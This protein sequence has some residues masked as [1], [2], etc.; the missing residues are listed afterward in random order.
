MVF[1]WIPEF[2]PRW[3]DHLNVT[4]VFDWNGRYTDFCQLFNIECR[5]KPSIGYYNYRMFRLSPYNMEFNF[6]HNCCAFWV[7]RITLRISGCILLAIRCIPSRMGLI[8]RTPAA[9]PFQ[10]PDY[11]LRNGKQTIDKFNVGGHTVY[12]DVTRPVLDPDVS[13]LR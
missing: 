7:I 4:F 11:S 10:S 5:I 1:G 3:I 2:W 13:A 9:K 6:L 8:P 12:S